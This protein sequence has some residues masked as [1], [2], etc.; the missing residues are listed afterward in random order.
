VQQR[1]ALGRAF[2]HVQTEFGSVHIK[3]ATLGDDLR[4]VI[5]HRVVNAQPEY[6]DVRAIALAQGLPWREVHQ[7]AIGQWRREKG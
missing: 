4:S 2:E 7:L 5:D 1:T 6:E 3:V